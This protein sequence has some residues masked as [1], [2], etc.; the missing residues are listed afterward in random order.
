MEDVG[1]YLYCADRLLYQLKRSGKLSRL[2]GLV[3][4]GFTDSK[5][6]DRP[7]GKSAYEMIHD[8]V[9][10]YDYPICFDFP[11][12][13]NKENYALKIGVKYSLQVGEGGAVLR[14]L[15]EP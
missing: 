5:D 12:S 8:L 3:I 10:E 7:F 6:T 4:G 15:S 14:E 9:K 1:E 13:H 2:A 11:V